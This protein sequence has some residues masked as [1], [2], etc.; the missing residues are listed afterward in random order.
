MW[1]WVK[2]NWIAL[3]LSYAG[4]Y[5]LFGAS[6]FGFGMWLIGAAFLYLVSGGE[7]SSNKDKNK[8]NKK[9]DKD[10]P[11]LSH[12]L[13]PSK[14]AFWAG[15]SKTFFSLLKLWRR[16]G[17]RRADSAKASTK[18]AAE[19]APGKAKTLPWISWILYL[20]IITP[21]VFAGMMVNKNAGG[22]Y[23][24]NI[25]TFLAISVGVLIYG[26]YIRKVDSWK[27]LK[28]LVLSIGVGF[29]YIAFK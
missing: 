22:H 9:E 23:D 3:A 27:G 11:P 4:F 10:K 13:N 2:E 26:V 21:A 17:R 1:C 8:K 28:L 29:F 19:A 20:G 16:N 7:T 15:M 5:W 14:W 24:I 12:R 6:Q 18:A 25:I